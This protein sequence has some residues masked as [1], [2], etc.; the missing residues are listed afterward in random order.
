MTV[1]T[2]TEMA[3]RR[4]ARRSALA[5]LTFVSHGER[6]AATSRL[7]AQLSVVP[8]RTGSST[9]CV[10]ADTVTRRR[11]IM[12][13]PF[14]CGYLGRIRRTGSLLGPAFLVMCC[15]MIGSSERSRAR[16]YR[17]SLLVTEL[18]TC[19]GDTM[20]IIIYTKWIWLSHIYLPLRK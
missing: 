8:L 20:S 5:T 19:F 7:L 3:V 12:I 10:L 1:T 6:I 9:T 15:A 14:K 18:V 13:P 4:T 17:K 11:R 2:L 16:R